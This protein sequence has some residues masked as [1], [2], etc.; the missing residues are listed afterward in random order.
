MDNYLVEGNIAYNAGTF[1]IGGGKPS[2]NIRVFSNCLYEVS[3]QLGYNAPT[4][5]NCE[6]RGNLI[7]NGGLSINRF[8][9]IVNEDNVVLSGKTQPRP[10]GVRVILRPN[11]YDHDGANLAVFNWDKQPS[12]AVNAKP[13]LKRGDKYRLMDPRNFFGEP[14]LQGVYDGKAIRVPVKD[15]FAAFVLLKQFAK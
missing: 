14:V 13:F 2:H 9:K 5:D 8:E 12:V 7:V 11:K 4:N 3:M 1:L 15:E 6:V 10:A